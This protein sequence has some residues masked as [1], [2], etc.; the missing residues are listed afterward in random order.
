MSLTRP[1][2]DV[3]E[4]KVEKAIQF[5]VSPQRDFIG[6]IETED[7][8]P[9]NS[10]HVGAEGVR[11][12]RGDRSNE[13][14]DPFVETTLAFF[15]SNIPG[16]QRVHIILD[17]DWHNT[18]DPEFEVFGRHCVK[19]TDG[20]RLAEPLEDYR[21]EDRV[22]SIRANSINIATHPRYAQI[23]ESIIG[24]TRIERTRVGVCGVWTNIK[25]E[26]LMFNLATLPPY[27]PMSSIGVCEPLTAAPEQ[28]WHDAA[29]EK[30]RL[31]GFQVLDTI[32]D[33]LRWMG[34]EIPD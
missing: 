15:D 20:A 34:L 16:S 17:E 21:W 33:Y 25:I 30:F 8:K 12:L 19:G 31:M 9:P 22:H 7:G 5:L 26:Y 24:K 3:T 29:I 28:R 18:S 27:F 1:D 2:Q 6:H 32:P 10:L 13:T 23:I 11:K 4:S 14:G